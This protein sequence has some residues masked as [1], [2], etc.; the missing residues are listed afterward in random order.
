VK[1]GGS[2]NIDKG[3]KLGILFAKTVKQISWHHKGD[4]FSAVAPDG[5]KHALSI[6]QLSQQ[7]T[8]YPFRRTKEG[9]VQA[10]VFHPSK[11]IFFVAT[12]RFVRVYNL[13]KQKLLT[14]VRLPH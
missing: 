11:P 8:Q 9:Q 3:I 14:K 1:P 2:N 4:Y 13:V 12:Q 10:A 5:E 6:H 7:R